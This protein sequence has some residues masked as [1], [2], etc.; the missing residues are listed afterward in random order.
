[1]WPKRT[2]SDALF[3]AHQVSHPNRPKTK[4]KSGP[5]KTLGKADDI[6]SETE[7]G[8]ERIVLSGISLVRAGQDRCAGTVSKLPQT[9]YA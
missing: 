5:R 9:P 3:P 6:S 2:N 4:D 8:Q 1:M 7:L